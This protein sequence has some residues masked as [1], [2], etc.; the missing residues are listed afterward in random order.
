MNFQQLIDKRQS[1]SFDQVSELIAIITNGLN[2][3]DRLFYRLVILDKFYTLFDGNM[4]AH[5]FF[6]Y[7]GR[8]EHNLTK[9]EL[10]DLRKYMK[11][12]F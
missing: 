5:K 12:T 2:K 10:Q 9:E 7:G 3:H 4:Y 11:E 6:I 1:L 8:V